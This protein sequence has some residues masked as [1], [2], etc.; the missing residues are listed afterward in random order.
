MRL[1]PLVVL[2]LLAGSLTPLHASDISELVKEKLGLRNPFKDIAAPY[3][4]AVAAPGFAPAHQLVRDD[5]D[6]RTYELRRDVP[7]AGPVIERVTA[8]APSSIKDG[9]CAG[10]IELEVPQAPGGSQRY[11]ADVGC[12]DGTSRVRASRVDVEKRTRWEYEPTLDQLMRARSLMLTDRSDGVRWYAP[13][14]AFESISFTAVA[15][16]AGHAHTG[17]ETTE[18]RNLVVGM[19]MNAGYPTP[20]VHWDDLQIAVLDAQGNALSQ[21][22]LDNLDVGTHLIRR[23]T[24]NNG[25]LTALAYSGLLK[26]AAG[27]WRFVDLSIPVTSKNVAERGAP[28]KVWG[29]LVTSHERQALATQ[30]E[31]ALGHLWVD[32]KEWISLDRVAGMADTVLHKPGGGTSSDFTVNPAPGQAPLYLLAHAPSETSRVSSDSTVM[33]DQLGVLVRLPEGVRRGWAHVHERISAD[34][35]AAPLGYETRQE[36][37]PYTTRVLEFSLL[38]GRR[39]KVVEQLVAVQHPEGGLEYGF[40]QVAQ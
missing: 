19:S 14:L 29:A 40:K 17:E 9:V 5:A 13:D 10:H 25:Q 12:V 8:R 33:V 1:R 6:G 31:G 39:V 26:D 16:A 28:A 3:K 23:E 24:D 35:T 27:A 4:A 21:L 7:G 22:L 36:K 30:P 38:G 34:G 37:G 11:V 15:H 32:G 2:L 18:Q 20:G